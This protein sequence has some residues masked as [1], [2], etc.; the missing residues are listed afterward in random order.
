[1]PEKV[2]EPGRG[3]HRAGPGLLLLR[4]WVEERQSGWSAQEVLP[5]AGPLC[6]LFLG[7]NMGR[8]A[9]GGRERS[10]WLQLSHHSEKKVAK[11]GPD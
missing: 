9:R 5:G 3:E 4:G 2:A 1:M 6:P 7:G 11:A 10:L 8:G